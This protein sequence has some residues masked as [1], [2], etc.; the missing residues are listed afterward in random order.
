MH[1][2]GGIDREYE[3]ARG[4]CT[5]WAESTVNTRTLA[6][7]AMRATGDGR[8]VGVGVDRA[9]VL[10]A[11]RR[12][13][14]KRKSSAPPPKKV[15]PKVDTQF[16]CPFCNHDKSVVARLDKTSEKG[17]VECVVCGQRYTCNITHLSEP[18][19]V[20]SDWIDA[21]E[22]VNAREGEEEEE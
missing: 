14:G 10:A 6:G 2:M 18:I 13:M 16:T 12:G 9:R 4:R 1:A 3:D 15:A 17:M 22:R 19:D 7:D 11:P 8:R 21:C 20:Y 5:R